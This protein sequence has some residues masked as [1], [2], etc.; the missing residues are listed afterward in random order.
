MA[1]EFS[2][3]QLVIAIAITFLVATMGTIALLS[4][5]MAGANAD[6]TIR[7]DAAAS[8]FY[9]KKYEALL[10]EARESAAQNEAA[11]RLWRD[12]ALAA[13]SQADDRHYAAVVTVGNRGNRFCIDGVTVAEGLDILAE[14]RRACSVVLVDPDNGD[15]EQTTP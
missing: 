12:R 14:L 2:T 11:A 15:G 3:V 10:Q 13:E 4:I 9:A 1:P 7:R 8:A 6:E 5:L